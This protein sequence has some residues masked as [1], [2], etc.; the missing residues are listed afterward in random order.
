MVTKIVT[1]QEAEGHLLEL[2]GL[3]ENKIISSEPRSGMIMDIS[4]HGVLAELDCELSIFSE[5]KLDIDLSLIGYTAANIYAKILNSKRQDNRYLSALEF[6]S[7]S[8]Q[9][10]MHIQQFVQLL[11]QGSSTKQT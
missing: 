6:T 11:V 9:S 8:V 2:I 7:V 5:I 1:V 3:V 10:N 4:Y